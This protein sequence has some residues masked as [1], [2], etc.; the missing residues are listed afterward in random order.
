[1]L[2][3]SMISSI[4]TL[5]MVVGPATTQPAIAPSKESVITACASPYQ[6]RV[7]ISG[8]SRIS[9]RPGCYE[10]RAETSLQRQECDSASKKRSRGLDSPMGRPD[11]F[12]AFQLHTVV[13]AAKVS[14][15]RRIGWGIICNRRKS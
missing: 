4:P 2:L 6:H 15:L 11:E 3:V 9:M 5:Q 12:L 1:M 10:E 8:P 7:T 14:G 13:G